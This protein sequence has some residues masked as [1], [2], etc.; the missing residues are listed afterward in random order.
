MALGADQKGLLAKGRTDP[1]LTV[2]NG[3]TEP[4]WLP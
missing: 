1:A 2:L 4:H 3:L